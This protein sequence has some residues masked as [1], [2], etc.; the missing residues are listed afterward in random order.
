MDTDDTSEIPLNP[1]GAPN[2]QRQSASSRSY[3]W[4]I[5]IVALSCS[6]A[7]LIA[8]IILLAQ[9]DQKPLGD[10]KALFS[11]NT[12]AAILSVVLRTPLAFAVGSCLG[13]GKW[14][15]FSKRSGP[16]AI[17]AA[18][19]E[20]SRGPMGSLQLLWRL[21]ARH[22]VSLGALITLA[23]VAIDPFLQAIISYEGKLALAHST[24]VSSLSCALELDIG[25]LEATQTSSPPYHGETGFVWCKPS[26]SNIGMSTSSMIGF[27][28][29]STSN[30]ATPPL[31]TCQTGNCTWAAYSTL[32]F[33]SSCFDVSTLL[34]KKTGPAPDG[35]SGCDPSISSSGQNV[36][37]YTIPYGS[38]DILYSSW[39]GY[40]GAYGA[41]CKNSSVVGQ[42]LVRPKDT[43][44]LQGWDT[45]IAA[46]VLLRPSEGYLEGEIPWENDVMTAT[47][48]G[49]RL[50]AKIFQPNV[51]DGQTHETL[52]SDTF[53]RVPESFDPLWEQSPIGNATVLGWIND[54]FGNSL[55]SRIPNTTCDILDRHDLQLRIPS[56]VL[57]SNELQRTF[58]VTHASI[59]TIIDEILCGSQRIFDALNGSTSFNKSFENAARLMSYQIR[60]LD[61]AKVYGVAQNWIVYVQI[62]WQFMIF[63][64]VIAILGSVFS[65]SV[66]LGSRK[67]KTQIMK[68][69]MLESMLHGLD[70]ET[71]IQLRKSK[72]KEKMEKN[73]IVQ[74]RDGPEG[75]RLQPH[76]GREPWFELGIFS[77]STLF[78]PSG[79]RPDVTDPN[80]QPSTFR[81]PS[82]AP[83]ESDELLTDATDDVAVREYVLQDV[84]E[85]AR[86]LYLEMESAGA[87]E[88]TDKSTEPADGSKDDMALDEESDS[89]IPSDSDDDEEGNIIRE[90]KRM[91]R[92]LQEVIDRSRRTLASVGADAG[93]A[94]APVP[95]NKKRGEALVIMQNWQYM[96]P[97]DQ[98]NA[99]A[100]RGL[101]DVNMYPAYL[102]FVVQGGARNVLMPC[103]QPRPLGG[104]SAGPMETGST[105]VE[106]NNEMEVEDESQGK[107]GGGGN[108]SNSEN[109]EDT[110]HPNQIDW[111]DLSDEYRAQLFLWGRWADAVD[112]N[113]PA[114]L[115]HLRLRDEAKHRDYF[116]EITRNGSAT[117]EELLE[118][119]KQSQ[120]RRTAANRDATRIHRKK[121]R[122]AAF[123]QPPWRRGRSDPY[124]LRKSPLHR[125]RHRLWRTCTPRSLWPRRVGTKWMVAADQEAATRI[126]R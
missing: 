22:W 72:V 14:S 114:Y 13:Q 54:D 80:H 69:S 98:A 46:F 122:K 42:T 121:M 65:V 51:T 126:S 6:A 112:L 21:K 30:L 124:H 123:R 17:F 36:T 87:H 102:N 19:D 75:L 71:S 120:E 78:S 83:S 95:A 28:N 89:E 56:A 70:E 12:V 76:H 32:A 63:P 43:Y 20:A 93:P 25:L 53:E 44:N 84:E 9:E 34:K 86:I 100:W 104:D 97:W 66:M 96:T 117:Q 29:S 110:L 4:T 82:T 49:L 26:K 27:V 5:E 79:N 68:G 8:L 116:D 74:L 81:A 35:Y 105:L 38:S 37:F 47:E 67:D 11:L 40:R 52:L 64:I 55:H 48:C 94:P 109:S 101:Y 50:C 2:E 125:H 62:R 33:C 39:E 1:I 58:I 16:V 45:L 57:A 108:V 41:P 77:R 73:V 106:N 111:L 85:K 15:W 119:L 103:N 60:E 59:T 10:W 23:L 3:S 90:V 88:D 24:G 118:K 113:V 61:G 18:I 92:E 31:I 7:A 115:R 91:R 99:V 107:E